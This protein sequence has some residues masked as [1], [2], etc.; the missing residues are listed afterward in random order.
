MEQ[1]PGAGIVRE[2]LNSIYSLFACTRDI[3]RKYGPELAPRGRAGGVTFAGIAVEMVNTVLRPLLTKWHPALAEWE[4]TRQPG[5]SVVVHE[6]A[7]SQIEDLRSE[8]AETRKVLLDLA[9]D[10]HDAMQIQ[11]LIGNT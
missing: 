10:L 3:L 7:W 11:P 1:K 4:A 2:E 6:R 9:A 8:V 5:A